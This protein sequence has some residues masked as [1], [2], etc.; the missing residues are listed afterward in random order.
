MTYQAIVY[1]RPGC[2]KCRATKAQLT[3]MG[4]NVTEKQIDEHEDKVA[5]MRENG[6]LELPLVEVELPGE[7]VDRWSGLNTEKLEALRYLIKE[8]S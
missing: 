6:W 1:S 2:M 3:K 5:I 8:G 7:G 4:A